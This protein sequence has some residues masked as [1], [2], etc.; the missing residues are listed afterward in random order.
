[1]AINIGRNCFLL[2]EFT[3][4]YCSNEDCDAEI[5]QVCGYEEANIFEL[6]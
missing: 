1:M 6:Q 4:N 5:P 2:R 3:V